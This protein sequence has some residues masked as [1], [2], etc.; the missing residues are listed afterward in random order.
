MR[1]YRRIVKTI[2]ILITDYHFILVNDILVDVEFDTNNIE[3]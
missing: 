2:V 1:Y 3:I